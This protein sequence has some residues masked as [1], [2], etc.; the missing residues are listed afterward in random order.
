MAKAKPPTSG[1]LPVT[2]RFTEGPRC[3]SCSA[4]SRLRTMH[5]ADVRAV[6]ALVAVAPTTG[7]CAGRRCNDARCGIEFI[8]VSHWRESTRKP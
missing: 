7:P 8:E 6:D 3:P 5:E 2:P 4:S 1:A